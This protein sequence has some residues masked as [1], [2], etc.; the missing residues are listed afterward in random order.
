MNQTALLIGLIFVA[1][2]GFTVAL[3]ITDQYQRK[4]VD[5]WRAFSCNESGHVVVQSRDR[6]LYCVQGRLVAE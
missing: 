5:A 6:R 2:T 1:I 3:D 4:R